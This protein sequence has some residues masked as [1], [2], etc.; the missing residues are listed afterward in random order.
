MGLVSKLYQI[1]IIFFLN[2]SKKHSILCEDCAQSSR[3]LKLSIAIST[4]LVFAS[5]TELKTGENN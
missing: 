3:C 4:Y 2:F 5:A 1:V